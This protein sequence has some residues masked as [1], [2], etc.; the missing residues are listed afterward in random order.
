MGE[1]E[2][3]DRHHSDRMLHYPSEDVVRFIVRNWET[4]QSRNGLRALD[5][6][7][8]SGRHTVYLAKEGFRAYGTDISATGLA[9]AEQ[10]LRQEGASA[11]LKWSALDNIPYQDDFFDLVLAWESIHYGD[12]A[13]GRRVGGEIFRVLKSG[14]RLFIS[15]RSRDDNHPGEE[16]AERFTFEGREGEE[17][18]LFHLYDRKEAL[19]VL[20]GFE[21]VYV[22]RFF[23]TRYDQSQLNASFMIEAR[24]VL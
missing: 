23:W 11:E 10:F 7:C 1:K 24:K 6:G 4:S 2:R 13:F 9:N 18:L 21:I 22:D 12:Y 15:F 16:T 3:W 5:L 8:G 17:G 14:G 20:E 19:S